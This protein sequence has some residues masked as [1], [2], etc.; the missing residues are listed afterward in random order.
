MVLDQPNARDYHEVLK[1]KIMT[2]DTCQGEE[3]DVILYSMV[4]RDPT[5]DALNYIFPVNLTSAEERAADALKYLRLN[6]GFPRAKECPKI[7][8]E[9]ENIV[10]GFLR[11]SRKSCV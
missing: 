5:H 11:L 9:N 3:R 8:G 1:L 10:Y 4:D 2:F 6:V 7:H